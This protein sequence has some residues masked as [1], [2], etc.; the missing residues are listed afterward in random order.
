MSKGASM[1]ALQSSDSRTRFSRVGRSRS[2]ISHGIDA[3]VPTTPTRDGVLH[4]AYLP[5]SS[6]RMITKGQSLLATLAALHPK[7]PI[8][9]LARDLGHVASVPLWRCSLLQ[10]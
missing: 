6:A 8:G 10:S 7:V 5:K 4:I 1:C 3:G 9:L 2:Q